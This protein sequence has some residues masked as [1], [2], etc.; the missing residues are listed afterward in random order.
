MYIED[1]G[2]CQDDGIDRSVSLR[3]RAD[4]NFL[5]SCHQ[6]RNGIHEKAGHQRR[7]AALA[8]GNIEAGPGDRIYHLPQYASVRAC[9]KP[10]FLFLLFMEGT[11]VAGCLGNAFPGFC[12]HTGRSHGYFLFADTQRAIE[13]RT[14]I[15]FCV[16]DKGLITLFFDGVQ[17]IP[18]LG[19]HIRRSRVGAVF[20]PFAGS[21]PFTGI[22]Q[23]DDTTK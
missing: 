9:R 18:D 15:L 14:V 10:G 8:T 13:V 2:C 16:L 20:Q 7:L 5:D 21:R 19:F 6:G 1:V 3:R 17:N 4:G 11:Y 22:L 12:R 23:I